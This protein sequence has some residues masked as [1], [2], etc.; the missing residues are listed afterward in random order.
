MKY[1]LDQG[2]PRSTVEYLSGMAIE[3][4]H[5][6]NLGMASVIRIR[7]ESIK[8]EQVASVIQQVQAV[9]ASD[10]AERVA[11]TMT[12][13]RIVIRRLPLTGK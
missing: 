10:L 9:A 6:G 1:S 4:D 5:V 7:I 13:R 11:V 8:G 12:A 2:L 3:S